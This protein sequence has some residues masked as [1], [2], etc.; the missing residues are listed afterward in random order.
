LH[1][2]AGSPIIWPAMKIATVIGARPQFIKYAP[3]SR[4]LRKNHREILIHTGQHYDYEMDRVFFQELSIPEPD[5]NLQVGSGRHGAQTGAMLIELEKILV[6]EKPELV[7]VYGDTNSTL[8][9]ALAAVK[10]QNSIAHVEA[11][12]RSFDRT[13]PEEINRIVTDHCSDYLFCPTKTA[14][15]N[16]ERE[17]V[18]GQIHL[19]GD[20]TVD[21][22]SDNIEVAQRSQVLEKL[23]MESKGYLLVTIHR[24]SNTDCEPNLINIIEALLEIDEDIVLPLHPRTEKYLKAY[25]LYDKLRENIRLIKPLGYLDFLKLMSS[26]RKILTD[27]GGIQKEAYILGVPCITLRENTEWVETVENGWNILAGTDRER[28]VRTVREFEP[29][30]EPAE[31]FGRDASVKISQI[32]NRKK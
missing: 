20:V 6:Q 7:I 14:V 1:K 15:T 10:L 5:Y 23:G 17:R 9:G 4:E 2:A 30:G 13:M 26:A 31:V 21:V 11:G 18:A 19:T 12:L 28:I 8:A 32:I 16:L 25:G 27:S 24:Q 22:L 3:L 29:E